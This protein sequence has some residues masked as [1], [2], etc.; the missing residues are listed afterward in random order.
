MTSI[1]AANNDGVR[2]SLIRDAIVLWTIKFTDIGEFR[3]QTG[4]FCVLPR[5]SR[6]VE[7]LSAEWLMAG[8]DRR[9]IRIRFWLTFHYYL[10]FITID[11]V[12]YY[13]L[14]YGHLQ[15]FRPIWQNIDSYNEKWL[16]RVGS[17]RINDR[18]KLKNFIVSMVTVTVTYG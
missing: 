11:S 7:I 2:A 16:C 6:S 13:K 18:T 8:S 10:R 4:G 9:I 14:R 17:F 12:Q 1:L 15:Y 5:I 3:R